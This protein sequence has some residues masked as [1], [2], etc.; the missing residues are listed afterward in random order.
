MKLPILIS[1]IALILLFFG[2][3]TSETSTAEIHNR[4]VNIHPEGAISDDNNYYRSL[5]DYLKKVPGINISGSE[6]N[7]M[8]T[9]R[10]ISSFNSGIEPLFVID[11][12]AVGSS[13]SQANSMLNVQD[14]DYV[15]VL[16]GAD[17][18]FYGVRGG[19]GVVLIVTR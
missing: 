4:S 9:V 6:N 5:A 17:A 18:G 12:V 19:N 7:Q 13:Y 14:I 2:C 15:R 1:T 3:S 8:V 10:G 16:K 11:G